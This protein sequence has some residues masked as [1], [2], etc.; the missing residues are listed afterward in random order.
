[1]G[2][3]KELIPRGPKRGKGGHICYE[4]GQFDEMMRFPAGG[5]KCCHQI[6]KGLHGLRGYVTWPDYLA[7]GV[8]TDLPGDHHE[9]ARMR[10]NHLAIARRGRESTGIE[11]AGERGAHEYPW[12]EDASRCTFERALSQERG[13]LRPGRQRGKMDLQGHEKDRQPPSHGRL[14]FMG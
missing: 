4:G 14:S 10:D 1:M 5:R 12:V 13:A 3:V 9:G 11:A 7:L 8:E 2:R 6:A